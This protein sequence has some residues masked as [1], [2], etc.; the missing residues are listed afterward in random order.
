MVNKSKSTL[1]RPARTRL[2]LFSLTLALLAGMLPKPPLLLAV[3]PDLLALVLLYWIV[4][5]PN[6]I[7][8]GTAW[9]L[10]LLVDV[11]Q[12]SLFGQHALVYAAMAFLA[13]LL[14]RRLLMFN[15]WQQALQLLPLLLAGHG[16]NVIL[17]LFAGDAF[18]GW[19]YFIGSLLSAALWPVVTLLLQLPQKHESTPEPE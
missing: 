14:R 15:L 18:I 9:L 1:L 5:Q 16:L 2:I 7:G 11:G 13:T 6:R 8:M 10:G 17:H 12:G 3:F 19:P 4:H